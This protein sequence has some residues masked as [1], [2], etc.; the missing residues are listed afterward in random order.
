MNVALYLRRSTNE[1]LQADSLK[2]QE[3][4][5]RAYAADHGMDVVEV[6]RDSA[7]GTS[8]KHRVAFLKMV[9]TI[10]H[11]ASFS[12]VL[13][14]DVSRFG[15]FFDVDEGAFFEVLFL[16]HGVKTVYCEEVFASDTSPMASLVKN[17]RRVMASE[18]S[19]D[20]SRLIRYAQSRAT[21]LGFHAAGPPPY[22]MR[23]VMIGPTGKH[24]QDLAKGE[25][26]ALANHRTRLVAGDPDAVDVVRRIFDLYDVADHGV[27]TIAEL[28]NADGIAAPQGLRWH[29][30]TVAGVLSNSL[31]AGLGHYTPKRKG[32]S[33]PLPPSQVE[34][35][36]VRDAEGHEAIISVEQFRR[37]E[38]KRNAMT[39]RRSND[40]LA[41][42]VRRAFEQHG[43]V[44]PAMLDRLPTHCSWAT[45]S[46]R[47]PGGVD[48]AL[49]RA[50]VA[51]IA[52]RR[53]QIIDLLRDAF[54][55]TSDA[56]AWRVDATLRCALVPL[57]RHRRR[58]GFFWRILPQADAADLVV[59]FGIPGGLDDSVFVVRADQLSNRPRGLFLRCD[60]TRAA[61]RYTVPFRKL[62]HRIGLLRYTAS[63]ASEA[64]LLDAARTKTL[65]NFAELARELEWPHQAVRKM[66]WR[67]LDRGEW[68]PP[69]KCR[70]G[71]LLEI[72]CRQCGVSRWELPNRALA[73]RTDRCFTCM[74]KQPRRRITIRCPTCGR[75]TDR[76]PSAVKKL[77]NGA[78]TVCR[79][80]RVKAGIKK[81]ELRESK[82]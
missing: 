37:V 57:F 23:R 21:R 41:A 81:R 44:E 62:A 46:V 6:F 61:A 77:S 73:L 66:Y 4:I 55:V 69:L 33:D 24:V 22:G 28:L 60:G 52:D 26:K 8:T 2:V 47:F 51:E 1:R 59:A 82:V 80:C 74:T 12:S 50:Y 63:A 42:D 58:T 15:R 67:L 40:A 56:T 70:A 72:I 10:T 5:L 13:V 53:E 38:E 64:R 49:S 25:W 54:V 45:Y 78:S 76:W 31:Y 11:G 27:S 36:R 48:E 43:C 30:P 18:Y 3:Q 79:L 35:L 34:D 19:R 16:G 68:F 7:S 14:R 17:V 71:R 20:R 65:T 39:R 32:L 9:E 75:T 29:E